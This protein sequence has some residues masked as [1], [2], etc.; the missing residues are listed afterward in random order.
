MHE[1]SLMESVL[2]IVKEVAQA[3]HLRKVSTITLVVGELSGVSTEAL[4]FAFQALKGEDQLTSQADLVIEEKKGEANCP[5][6]RKTIP[7]WHFDLICPDCRMPMQVV[8]GDD[9]Y[10]KTI[11][12]EKDG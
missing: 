5:Q 1:F 6:C 11:T 4:D 7:I 2:R 8:G 9:F 12:G 3:N 10:V